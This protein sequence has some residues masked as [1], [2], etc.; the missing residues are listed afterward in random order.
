M[1]GDNVIDLQDHLDQLRGQQE[2]LSLADVRINDVLFLQVVGS[3]EETVNT[4]P[5]VLFGDLTRL[6][7]G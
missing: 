2:L 3:L 7:F 4:Q 5:E 6:D 1:G